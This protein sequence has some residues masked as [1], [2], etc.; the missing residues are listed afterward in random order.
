MLRLWILMLA[1]AFVAAALGCNSSPDGPPLT[2]KNA[3]GRLI[4]PDGEGAKLAKPGAAE[5]APQP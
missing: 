3:R 5:T 1:I 2:T 4:G